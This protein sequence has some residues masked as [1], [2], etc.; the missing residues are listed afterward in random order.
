MGYEFSKEIWKVWFLNILVQSTFSK[1][2][3][4]D[5]KREKIIAEVS[6][7][8]IYFLYNALL[9][10]HFGQILADLETFYDG[11]LKSLIQQNWHKLI[12]SKK[13]P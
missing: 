13:F 1:N 8:A 10:M 6:Q 3:V 12:P 7:I 11:F 2:Q 9:K 4:F 5:P